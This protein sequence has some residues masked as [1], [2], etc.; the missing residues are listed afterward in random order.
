MKKV[1][2]TNPELFNRLKVDV[3]VISWGNQYEVRIIWSVDDDIYSQDWHGEH[4]QFD[5]EEEFGFQLINHTQNDNDRE[6]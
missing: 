2:V 6:D 4:G 5:Y 1:L 3:Q